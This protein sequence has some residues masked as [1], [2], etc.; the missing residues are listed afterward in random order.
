MRAAILWLLIPCVWLHMAMS[1]MTTIIFCLHVNRRHLET[2]TLHQK[3]PAC[4]D[5]I[6]MRAK[7]LQSMPK[8]NKTTRAEIQLWCRVW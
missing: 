4:Q 1:E 5:Q 3:P 6:S 8:Y 2:H 7:V